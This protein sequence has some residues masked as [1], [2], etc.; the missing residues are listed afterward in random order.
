M[1]LLISFYLIATA[2]CGR[3]LKGDIWVDYANAGSMTEIS[4]SFMLSNAIN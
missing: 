3:I 4:F 1:Q 2:L